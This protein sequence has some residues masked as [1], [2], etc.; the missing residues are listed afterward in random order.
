MQ[1]D[2][3]YYDGASN[4]SG[5]MLGRNDK[6]KSHGFDAPKKLFSKLGLN[7]LDEDTEN[8]ANDRNTPRFEFVSNPEEIEALMERARC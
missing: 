6:G 3:S 5:I 2:S 8:M 7:K 1:R 4:V